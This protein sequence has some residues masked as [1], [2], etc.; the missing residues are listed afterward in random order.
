[1]GTFKQASEESGKEKKLYSIWLAGLGAY[2]KGAEEISQLST[3]SKS[4]YTEL[5]DHG[6][7]VESEM[8]E[9]I[10]TTR[11]HT[12]VVIEERAHQVMQ[13]LVGIDNERIDRIDDKLDQ[14]TLNIEALI[15][16]QQ[17]K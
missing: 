17:V 10:H 2:S 13:K 7:A 12:S 1:M 14:L 9:R 15:E 3:K 5:V 11:I 4:A 16:R 8:K 6:R